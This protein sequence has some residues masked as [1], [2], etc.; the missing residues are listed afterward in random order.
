MLGIW[1]RREL[2]LGASGIP[3]EWRRQRRINNSKNVPNALTH[4]AG[5][6]G[7]QKRGF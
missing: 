7:S 4:G 2:S 5:L 3:A 1:K 6:L